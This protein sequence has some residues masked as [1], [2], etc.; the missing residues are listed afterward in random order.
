VL[1]SSHVSLYVLALTHILASSSVHNTAAIK[2]SSNI[3]HGSESG[4]LADMGPALLVSTCGRT[5]FV[6]PM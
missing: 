4:H 2:V 6:C 3:D 1:V 5:V